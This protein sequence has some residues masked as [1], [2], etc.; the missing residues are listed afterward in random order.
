MKVKRIFKKNQ[1]VLTLLAVMIAVAG[2]LNYIGKDDA[3]GKGVEAGLTDI[4]DEDILAENQAVSGAM[5]QALSD[6]DEPGSAIFTSGNTVAEFMTEI[7]LNKEQ[8]RARNKE[9]LLEIVNSEAL[10]DEQK[11]NAVDTMVQMTSIAE[12]ENAAESV[13]G[14][15]GFEDA[16]VSITD[17]MADV[18]VGRT[19]L[20]DAERAQIEDVIKRKTD[21][22]IENITI[23]LM[24]EQSDIPTTEGAGGAADGSS[25]SASGN[26]SGNTSGSVTDPSSGAS[27]TTAA[28]ES[29]AA[30]TEAAE[31]K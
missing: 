24:N 22:P 11:Q 6:S 28:P 25:G 9:T 1:I 31:E 29:A 20:T 23:S 16:M 21:I 3:A 7:S 8:T 12:L 30:T 10:S 4:S 15:K 18:I 5:D 14:A 27:E 19:S 26:G 2:Y 13:L 17:G